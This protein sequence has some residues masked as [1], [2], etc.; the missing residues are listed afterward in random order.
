[1]DHGFWRLC[2]YFVL[3]HQFDQH[4]AV[5]FDIYRSRQVHDNMLLQ[6]ETTTNEHIRCYCFQNDSESGF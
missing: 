6:Y 5:K 3:W 4:R 2:G 1:M